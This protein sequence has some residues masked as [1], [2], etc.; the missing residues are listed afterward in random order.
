[1]A[2]SLVNIK[3]TKKVFQLSHRKLWWFNQTIRLLLATGTLDKQF[4]F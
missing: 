1:M 2:N 3:V 4:E